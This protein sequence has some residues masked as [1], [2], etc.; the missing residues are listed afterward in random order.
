[1]N[2]DTFI[3]V[4]MTR[5]GMREKFLT[6]WNHCEAMLLNG[7]S[8]QLSVGPSEEPITIK[9]RKFFKDI[10]CGQ[11]AEQV[12]IGD[13]RERFT[14]QAWAEYFRKRFLGVNGN[15][16]VMQKLPGQKKATPVKQRISTESLGVKRYSEHID[17]VIDHAVVEFHVAFHFEASEREAVRYVTK[18]RRS[19]H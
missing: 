17:H 11:I 3:T 15:K 18:P 14:K 16:Y 5:E 2:S 6:G 19:A 9:Q 12:F 4:I 13:R 8:V 1:M 10:V 7:E